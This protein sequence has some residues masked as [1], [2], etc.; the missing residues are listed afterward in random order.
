[1]KRIEKKAWP[2]LFDKMLS[3][4]KNFDLRLAE[5]ECEE[6]D[7]LVL[8]EWEPKTKQYTGRELEKEITF[9]IKTK[10]MKFWS[11]EEMDKLGFVVMS[12]K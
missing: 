2:E 5:F 3:G 11:K 8:K 12:F 6:G 9:V 10:D 4:E 7:I 1:M